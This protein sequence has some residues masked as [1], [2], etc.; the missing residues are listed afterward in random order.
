MTVTI[1]H[2]PWCDQATHTR[3]PAIDGCI[4]ASEDLHGVTTG[5]A[6][7]P[8]GVHV[9]L[10]TVGAVPLTLTS[11]ADL[12]THLTHLTHLIR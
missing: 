7:T 12:V 6:R 2:E 10:E 1:R 9:V 3:E 5:I 11:V 8:D 4:S